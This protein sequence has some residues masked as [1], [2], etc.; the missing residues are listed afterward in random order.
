MG[1][2][3]TNDL[4][5]QLRKLYLQWLAGVPD[6]EADIQDYIGQFE[7]DSRALISKL[8]GQAASLGALAGFP[9]PTTLE[10]SQRADVIYDQMKQ[11]AIKASIAA[12][13]NATDAARQ[14]LN[15]GIG[16]SFNELNRL[17]RTET[18]SAYWSNQWNSVA[19]LTGDG[20]DDLVMVWSSEESPVTC[21]YCDAR[22]GMVVD[23]PDIRDH[24]NGRCTLIPTLRSEVDYIGSLLADGS[25]YMDPAWTGR[26][27]RTEDAS[28][29]DNISNVD[30]QDQ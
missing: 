12:G 22:D 13:L 24:P 25:I 8:G 16:K 19:G 9:V 6:H 11:A 2:V 26:A 10:L 15:A 20:D 7:A 1:T 17:A 23:D 29:K 4:E 3:P 18:V 5:R 21:E 30:E 14:I 27:A 28:P